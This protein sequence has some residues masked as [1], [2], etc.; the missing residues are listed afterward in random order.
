MA[1]E[2]DLSLLLMQDGTP[3]HA[4]E[5]TMEALWVERLELNTWPPLSPDLN[6]IES[7]W[8]TLKNNTEVRHP[9]VVP[10]RKLSQ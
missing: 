7:D 1:N 2:A 5:R 3:S 6:P 10:G 9:K 8:N 4:A